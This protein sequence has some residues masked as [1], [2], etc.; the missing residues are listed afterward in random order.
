MSRQ[1][2]NR[3]LEHF[4]KVTTPTPNPD[5]LARLKKKLLSNNYTQ[6]FRIWEIYVHISTNAD[7]EVGCGKNKK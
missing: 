3:T 4:Q 1:F 2:N 5:F 7:L 6:S